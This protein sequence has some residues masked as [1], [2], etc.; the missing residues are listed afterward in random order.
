MVG[1]TN[2]SLRAA[3][4]GTYPPRQCGIATFTQDLASAVEA[5]RP[6]FARKQESLRSAELARGTSWTTS[7]G[8]RHAAGARPG[9]VDIV[10]VDYEPRD[11]PAEVQFRLD[12]DRPGDY[13]AAADRVNR[14]AYD[15]ISIQHEF[16]IY[17]GRDGE[18]IVDLLDELEIPAVTTLHTV[19]AHPSD[20]QRSV[21]GR[22]AAASSRLVVLSNAAAGLLTEVYGIDRGQIRVIP[23]GVPDLPFVDPETVKPLVGLSG[24]PTV[25]S[26]GLLGPGKGYELAIRAMSEVVRQAPD[27]CYVI[28]GATHP[29]LRR[30]EGEAYRLGLQQLVRER[31]LEGHVRFID[32]YV[33]LAMLGRWLQ[34]ADIFVTPYPGAEQAVSGTLAYALGS[35]KA[36]VSTP[37]AYAREL[38]A[39]GRGRLVPFG[40]SAALGRE[41]ADL[42]T[43]GPTRDEA[44]RRAYAYGRRMT[45][46]RVGQA[47]RALFHEVQVEFVGVA[48]ASLG[49][50]SEVTGVADHETRSVG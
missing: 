49:H 1:P 39:D 16:G 15:V 13:L 11:F 31:Q 32:A 9:V 46:P 4:V 6:E 30:H 36:I 47:Y 3:F 14:A 18:R 37:Y 2:R 42:L 40:D 34:A 33:D 23:H 41:I 12:P 21:I 25:L 45:W 10:A 29:E 5:T 22:I 17:G 48:P 28:L 43:D 50:P 26:F 44:R 38:L 19:L 8:P 7:A 35:G 20:H 24:R 27:T